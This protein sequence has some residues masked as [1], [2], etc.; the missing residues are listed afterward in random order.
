MQ[1]KILDF[2]IQSG[3]GLI[4]GEDNKRY[5]FTGSEWKEQ[6]LP[7]R[8]MDVDFEINEQGHATGIYVA[9]VKPVPSLSASGTEIAGSTA[10]GIPATGQNTQ[11]ASSQYAVNYHNAIPHSPSNNG[12]PDFKSIL[13]PDPNKSEAQYDY[14]DWC[15]KCLL[16]Y[17]NFEGRARRKE[18]WAFQFGYI[19][20]GILSLIL[21]NLFKLG[22]TLFILLILALLLPNL[23]VS[24]RRLH[25]V[26]RP[27]WWLLISFV[28]IIGYILLII[29][30]AKDGESQSNPYGAPAK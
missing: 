15:K 30:F 13:Q 9:M 19:V 18:F 2:S 21:G 23:A 4:T 16:N 27:G 26:G 1:G 28:P 10:A 12:T 11:T 17:V 14:I 8:G 6:Q 3:A 25:D 22:D 29:W 24:V 5:A 7:T 20:L